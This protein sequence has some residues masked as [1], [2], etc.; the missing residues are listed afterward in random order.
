MIMNEFDQ[1]LLMH[2]VCPLTGGKL[3]L[4]EEGDELLCKLSH[5]AYPVHDGVPILRYDQARE[6]HQK[7]NDD[8]NS[9]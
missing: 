3:V 2:L 4:S 6:L 1:D 9:I 7:E 5:L 8:D